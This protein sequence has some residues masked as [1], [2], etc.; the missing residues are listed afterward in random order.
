MVASTSPNQLRNWLNDVDFPSNKQDLLDAAGR[1]GCDDEIILA[2]KSASHHR[3]MG[4]ESQSQLH[5]VFV[6]GMVL[7]R[8]SN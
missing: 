3:H 6:E 4:G 1:N 7:P 5:R 8:R 2:A